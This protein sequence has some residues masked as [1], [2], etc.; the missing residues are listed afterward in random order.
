M[1]APGTN[2]WCKPVPG[3]LGVIARPQENPRSV[4][5]RATRKLCS[6]VMSATCCLSCCSCDPPTRCGC[7]L[8]VPQTVCFR[9]GAREENAWEL[10]REQFSQ[11]FLGLGGGE[12]AIRPFCGTPSTHPPRI[13]R[14]RV[15]PPS[16]STTLLLGC[17]VAS[18]PMSNNGHCAWP[19]PQ[20]T[21][22]QGAQHETS[23]W[24]RF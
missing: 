9:L 16:P 19:T 13:P 20:S 4:E 2:E 21:I 18:S 1:F 8:N 3:T 7:K 11:N 14:G 6:S 17:Q 12:R 24:G 5:Y 22:H 10:L 15:F 23:R